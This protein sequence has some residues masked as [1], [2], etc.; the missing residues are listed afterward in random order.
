MSTL[1]RRG[2]DRVRRLDAAILGLVL[3]GL[4]LDGLLVVIR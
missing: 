2:R 4:A 3:V 1:M